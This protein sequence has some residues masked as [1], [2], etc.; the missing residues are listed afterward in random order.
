MNNYFVLKPTG[1]GNKRGRSCVVALFGT[2]KNMRVVGNIPFLV[3]GM[4]VGFELTSD[5]YVT[6]Y[7]LSLTPNNIQALE[8]AGINP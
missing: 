1:D 3:H 7:S 2:R 6:D 8:K 4:C 5:N